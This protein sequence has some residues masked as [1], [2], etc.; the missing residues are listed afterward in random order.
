MILAGKDDP[1]EAMDDGWVTNS[2]LEVN[3]TAAVLRYTNSG[4]RSLVPLWLLRTYRNWECK[5]SLL[6]LTG[7]MTGLKSHTD[8]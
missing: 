8:S 7:N 5:Y 6:G 3:R 1:G 4:F 2:E